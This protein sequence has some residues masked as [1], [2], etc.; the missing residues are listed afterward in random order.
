M[1]NVCCSK[2]EADYDMI[3]LSEY[4]E[5]EAGRS[6]ACF[7]NWRWNWYC[8]F[9]ERFTYV[10]FGIH[11][12]FICLLWNYNLKYVSGLCRLKL[13]ENLK[14]LNSCSLYAYAVMDSVCHPFVFFLVS[15][16]H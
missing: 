9:F 10:N 16:L 4:L 8:T 12:L 15:I 6:G 7:R 2:Y 11:E 1:M 5:T 13:L 14:L 3:A